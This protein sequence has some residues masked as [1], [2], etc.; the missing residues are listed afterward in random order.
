MDDYIAL[1]TYE[2][3]L[4]FCQATNTLPNDV[5][6]LVWDKLNRYESRDSVCPGAPTKRKHNMAHKSERLNKLIDRWRELYGTP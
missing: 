5:Q 6:I 3:K 4:A 2:Y 1:H